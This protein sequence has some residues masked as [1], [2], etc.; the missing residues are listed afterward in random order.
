MPSMK[1][2]RSLLLWYN[3]RHLI[4]ELFQITSTF[5]ERELNGLAN[6]IRKSCVAITSNTGM[7]FKMP[8]ELRRSDFLNLAILSAEK[9]EID[10]R[11][12]KEKKL[13]TSSSFK[14][15]AQEINQIKE[16]VLSFSHKRALTMQFEPN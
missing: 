9:L 16:V 4:L 2:F 10:L 1:D 6:R 15:F 8:H 5:P 7:A 13:I 12:A 3:C 11:N 14:H